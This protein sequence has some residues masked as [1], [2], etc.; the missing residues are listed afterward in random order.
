MAEGVSPKFLKSSLVAINMNASA[1]PAEQADNTGA[2]GRLARGGATAGFCSVWCHG[3][4]LAT[5]CAVVGMM[6]GVGSEVC[7][8]REKA[9]ISAVA[10]VGNGGSAGAAKWLESWATA[11]K[12]VVKCAT[13]EDV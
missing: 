4:E 2:A 8:G 13:A 3:R 7:C 6:A 10:E 11:V 5:S 12:H 1:P 9:G